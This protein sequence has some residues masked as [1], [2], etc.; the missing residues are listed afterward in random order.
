ME[1]VKVYVD[2]DTYRK[3]SYDLARQVMEGGFM[4][5]F[6]VALWRGGTLPG[7]CMH[8]AF[9]WRAAKKGTPLVDHIAIRTSRYY[10]ID[11]AHSTVHVH[12]LGYLN[13]KLRPNTK[14][15]IVDDV[16]DT[17]ISIQAALTALKDRL[18]DNMPLDIRIA[19]IY[20]KPTRNKTNI[21]PNY[22]IHCLDEWIVFPHEV[23][24][25]TLEEIEKSRGKEVAEIFKKIDQL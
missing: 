5:D 10:G 1:P 19:T 13:E 12:N 7:T 20:Y 14:V 4:P 6:L 24:A 23:E 16:F 9:N 15:L 8:E 3:D 25:M 11:K 21:T 2:L 18:G 17:G 22:Y